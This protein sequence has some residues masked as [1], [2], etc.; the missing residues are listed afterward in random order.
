MDPQGCICVFAKAPRAGVVK[1]RLMPVLGSGGAAALATAFLQ[2]TLESVGSLPWAK[3]VMATT[4]HLDSSIVSTPCQIW[5]QGEGNLGVRLER[6]LHRALTDSSFAI[7]IGADSPGLPR[8]FLEQA[9]SALQKVDAVIGPCKDGGF[10]LL[11]LRRCPV[12]VFDGIAWSQSDT[13]AETLANL[14]RAGLTVQVLEPWF[15]VDRP[16]DLVKLQALV[17]TGRIHTPR[18]REVLDELLAHSGEPGPLKVS[19]IIPVL[20]EL[21]CLPET[22]SALRHQDWIHEVIAVDGGSTDGT[23]EW[24]RR[25]KEVRIIAAPAGKGIQLNAGAREAT[26]DTLI[27]LHADSRLPPDAEVSL[28]R[29]LDYPRVAGGGFCVKFS[30]RKPRLLG[31]VAAGI[32]LRTVLT[33]TATGEQAIF[34]RR[35]VF[36]E[37]GGFREWPLFEDVDV[38]SRMKRMGKFVVIRSRATVSARRYIRNGVIKIVMLVYLLRLGFWAGFSPFTLA[39]WYQGADAQP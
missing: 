28:K 8:A 1:T 2:D 11:G 19:V 24:L 37:I 30:S 3:A 32:N 23:L 34:I 10:Y 21:E 31:I 15:D 6:I 18:T 5:L 29:A 39:R 7:A 36:Q 35:G 22:L 20:N 26:G 4:E 12:G 14:R 27:F 38:V 33:H 16:E 9:R 17:S 25:Q 13:F